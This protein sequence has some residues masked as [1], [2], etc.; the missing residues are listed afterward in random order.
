VALDLGENNGRGALHAL[1]IVLRMKTRC[2][3]PPV[4]F[5][6]VDGGDHARFECRGRRRRRGGSGLGG[7][8]VV[9]LIR[10][11]GGGGRQ[12]QGLVAIDVGGFVVPPVQEERVSDDLWRWEMGGG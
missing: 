2:V 4:V 12:A 8:R 9:E 5:H 7:R 1:Q 10:E 6:R 3:E 11:G